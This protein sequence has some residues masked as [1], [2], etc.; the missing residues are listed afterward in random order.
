EDGDDKAGH[1]FASIM[2]V[3]FIFGLF[4]N[5]KEDPHVLEGLFECAKGIRA[6]FEIE[7][8]MLHLP[9]HQRN[10]ANP[11][12]NG[13]H[14]YWQ[15]VLYILP[16]T[17]CVKNTLLAAE[18]L[19]PYKFNL[20]TEEMVDLMFAEY[21]MDLPQGNQSLYTGVIPGE[22]R[23]QLKDETDKASKLNETVASINPD[24][25]VRMSTVLTILLAVQAST[26]TASKHADRAHGTSSADACVSGI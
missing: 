9:Q 14:K 13:P 7:S 12:T 2:K 8:S 24:P 25:Y 4:Q 22:A 10:R 17:I 11:P 26:V 6:K 18:Y 5:E 23:W 1:H 15:R 20:C 21:S 16:L 19:I 3:D